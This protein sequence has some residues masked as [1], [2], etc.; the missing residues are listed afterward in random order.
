[1][2]DDKS[3]LE[4]GSVCRRLCRRLTPSL[5]GFR[6][7]FVGQS[8]R[9]GRGGGGGLGGYRWPCDAAVQCKN[10]NALAYARLLIHGVAWPPSGGIREEGS[11]IRDQ[12]ARREPR[13]PWRLWWRLL[14]SNPRPRVRLCEM[15]QG[16]AREMAR[17]MD[18]YSPG[19]THSVM[20]YESTHKPWTNPAWTATAS[21]SDC[22]DTGSSAA[23]RETADQIRSLNG[24]WRDTGI[25]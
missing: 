14:I 17:Q 22:G 5:S 23:H 16:V 19:V 11:G 6:L 12:T 18:G 10:G 13:L 4:L 9:G 25:E 20:P 24:N 15:A 8:Q 2:L 7:G 21:W 3:A 1:M